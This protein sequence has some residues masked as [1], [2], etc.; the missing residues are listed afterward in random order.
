MHRDSSGSETSI[1]AEFQAFRKQQPAA[2]KL[3]NDEGNPT[4]RV[5]LFN[6]QRWLAERRRLGEARFV[7]VEAR[8]IAEQGRSRMGFEGGAWLEVEGG[9]LP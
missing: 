4:E 5:G 7:E 2:V 3:S 9:F 8:T 6:L 1:T